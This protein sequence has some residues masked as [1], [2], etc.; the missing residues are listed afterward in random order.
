MA[1]TTMDQLV[2]GVLP[3]GEDVLKTTFTAEAVGVQ[4]SAFYIAGRPGAAAVPSTG[5]AGAQLTSYAGSIPVPAAIAGENIY[6][7]RL[8]FTQTNSIGGMTVVDRLWHNS[9][10]SVTSTAAQSI[11]HPGIPARDNNGT[12]G[13]YGVMAAIEVTTTFTNASTINNINITYTNDQGVT[14][15]TGTVP[16]FPQT[17]TA[18]SWLPFNLQAGDT[19]VRSIQSYQSTSSLTSGALSLVLYREICA[20][21]SPA[22][23]TI[24]SAGP[25]ELGLPRIF[26]GSVLFMVYNMLGTA[27]GAIN[28]QLTFAQG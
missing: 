13:G 27:G 1:I 2:A 7:H 8:E 4:H 12:S 24:Y 3:Y 11:T 25:I 14:G 28:A 6:L 18:G 5:T 19:G 10:I 26:D 16:S 21:G 15:R 20:I 22:T 17:A 9:G 23:N